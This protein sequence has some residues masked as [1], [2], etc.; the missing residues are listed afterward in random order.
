MQEL[1][2]L[3]FSLDTVGLL[4]LIPALRA[5]WTEG[6]VTAADRQLFLDLARARGISPN[7]VGGLQL[8]EWVA[9][10]PDE[11]VFSHANRLIRALLDVGAPAT[12]QSGE[13]STA[14]E[15]IASAGSILGLEPLST[16]EQN[17]LAQLA[18]RK[19]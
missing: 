8:T 6:G 13:V 5:A 18:R 16:E 14:A 12:T 4:P 3:G 7:G 9:R 17:L 10:R 19:K 15:Q 11:A 2:D 1:H